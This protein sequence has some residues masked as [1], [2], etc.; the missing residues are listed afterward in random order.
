TSRGGHLA[1]R[2]RRGNDDQVNFVWL[3]PR[4]SNGV[5]PGMGSKIRRVFFWFSDVPFANPQRFEHPRRRAWQVCRDL[6]VCQNLGR[7]VRTGGFDTNT[8]KAAVVVSHS[9][10]QSREQKKRARRW[11]HKK[12]TKR[13]MEAEYLPFGI[14]PHPRSG[15]L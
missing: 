11:I 12:N 7:N 6:F 9:Y 5:Q 3:Q 4:R 13:A 10:L 15:E 1:V 8:I 2:C 14:P